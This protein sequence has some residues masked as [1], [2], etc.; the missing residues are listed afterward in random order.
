MGTSHVIGGELNF[1]L[2]T[3]MLIITLIFNSIIM[4]VLMLILNAIFMPILSMTTESLNNI[5]TDSVA[6][7]AVVFIGPTGGW[8]LLCPPH[9]IRSQELGSSSSPAT[10]HIVVYFAIQ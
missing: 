10:A 2:Q 4:A 3:L 5:A 7:E 9:N 8:E 6:I 1:N